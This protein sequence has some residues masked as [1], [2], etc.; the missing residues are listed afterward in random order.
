MLDFAQARR[1]MVD[2][3][4]RPFDVNDIPLLDAMNTIPRERFVAPGRESLAYMDQDIPVAD[5]RRMLSPMI[6]ARM[7]QNLEVRAGE[8]VLD[9][10]C[11]LGYTS[12]IM[13]ELGG[14]VI[15]LEDNEALAAAA[16]ERLAAAGF[17]GVAVVAGP[18]EQGYAEGAP[19]DAI[20]VNG[21]LEVQPD[22][23][24]RQLSEGGRLVC[25]QGRGRAAK[26]M[27]YVRARDAL[28][29]RSLFDAAAPVLAAFRDEP[30]FVF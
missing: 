8:R 23:L 20:L 29:Q 28:S 19:Y 17:A 9:V 30:G 22:G 11:G 26:A 18:L 1:I 4:L 13:A 24:L 7:I 27:L 16:R 21:A 10:A 3:Q 25:V 6:A 2:S 5:G 14:A 15:G 12:A